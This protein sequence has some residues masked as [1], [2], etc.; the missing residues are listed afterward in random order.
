M[1]RENK[2]KAGTY[3]CLFCTST[4]AAAANEN[5]E[6]DHDDPGAVIVKEMAKA[7]IHQMILH[8]MFGVVPLRYH[9]MR[10]AKKRDGLA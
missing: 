9:T 10:T 8:K 6:R 5:D 4:A 3:P 2:K 1:I 7:V